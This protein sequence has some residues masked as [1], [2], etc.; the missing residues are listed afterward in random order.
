MRFKLVSAALAF[1]FT[2]HAAH[3]R[4]AE[5]VERSAIDHVFYGDHGDPPLNAKVWSTFSPAAGVVADRV[6]YSTDA[7]M[8]VTAIVYRPDAASLKAAHVS[9]KLP[10]IVVVNGHGSDKFGW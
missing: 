1:A 4:Q 2:I 8:L 6:T 10:A 7:G 3:A 9:G 5:D